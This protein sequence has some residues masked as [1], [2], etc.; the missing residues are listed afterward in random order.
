MAVDAAAIPYAVLIAVPFLAAILA[1]PCC[2]QFRV[3]CSSSVCETGDI[4]PFIKGYSSLR[5]SITRHSAQPGRGSPSACAVNL[6]LKGGK[7][8]ALPQI[9][10]GRNQAN[11]KARDLDYARLAARFGAPPGRLR[12]HLRIEREHGARK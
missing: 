4:Q 7:E 2:G 3:L 1:A 6:R 12:K 8:E 11:V 5:E 10:V 9:A